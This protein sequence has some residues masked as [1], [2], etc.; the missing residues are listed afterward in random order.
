MS[1]NQHA[2]ADY[3]VH[4]SFRIAH[5]CLNKINTS[6]RFV[7]FSNRFADLLRMMVLH[8]TS[9]LIFREPLLMVPYIRLWHNIRLHSMT[10]F[11]KIG[12]TN[13]HLRRYRILSLQKH[14]HSMQTLLLCLVQILSFLPCCCQIVNYFLFVLIHK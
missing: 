13:T 4:N 1:N 8:Q 11:C 5:G 3:P 6:S 14:G 2:Q 9:S 12:I 10:H 7:R